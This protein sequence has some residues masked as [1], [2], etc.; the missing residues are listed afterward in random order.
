MVTLA[1]ENVNSTL[2]QVFDRLFDKAIAKLNLECSEDERREARENFALRF[3]EALDV[4]QNAG[5]GD[6]TADAANEMEST[7]NDLSPAHIAGYLAV[8]PLAVHLHKV[9]RSLAAKAAEQRLLDQLI[10]QA[11]DRYGGN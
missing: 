3:R 1:E 2:L 5:V 9:M 10:E 4:V 11:D 6:V 8:G 7:I